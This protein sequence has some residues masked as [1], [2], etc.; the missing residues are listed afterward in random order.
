MIPTKRFGRTEVQ[1]PVLSCGG[2]RYQQGWEDLDPDKI[3]RKGQENLEATVHR[4][5]ELGINHIETAR[6]YG[7][8]E[9]QLGWVLPKIERDKLLV[10]TKIGVKETAEEFLETFEVSMKNLQLESVDFLSIHGINLPEHIGTCLKKGGCM[11]AIRQLQKEGRVRFCGF[12]TH[13]GPETV[14]PACES[15]E[16][17]YVNLHWYFIYNQ[18]HWPMVETAAKMD[19]GVFIIS[20]NDKG[21]ML[22]NPTQ[23]MARLCEPLTPMQWN[24]LYCLARPEVHTLSIGAAR[25]EDFDE[26]VEAVSG[27]WEDRVALAGQIEAR[28]LQSLEK[29]V[30]AEWMARW[31]EGLPHYTETPGNINVKE[32]LRLWTFHKGLDLLEF[33]KMRYNLLGNADHWF[34]GQQATDAGSCDW[35]CL[36]ASP[37]AGRIP[38]ILRES[39][40]LF[41][42]DAEA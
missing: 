11:D 40:D 7:P 19:M 13:A 35:S 23:K 8:S 33:A 9:M 26:H 2:M 20:P 27:R 4:A 5:L 16:F 25:P 10:Q 1:M 24:D 37:F 3:E 34:P 18:L 14:V 22:Y 28:I 12:S 36:S 21:G 32:I 29:D 30:G 38:G 31:H 15:G 6:G 39:H 41:H 17:D 42:V